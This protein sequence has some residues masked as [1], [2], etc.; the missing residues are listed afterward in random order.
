MGTESQIQCV[1]TAIGKEEER[2]GEGKRRRKWRGKLEVVWRCGKGL[3]GKLRGR[4]EEG[5]GGGGE[6]W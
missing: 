1:E 2:V 3:G 4:R 6:G 5:W